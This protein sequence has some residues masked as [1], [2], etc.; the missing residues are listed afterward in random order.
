MALRQALGASSGELMR[1][2]AIPCGRM[3]RIFATVAGVGGV[4][5]SWPLCSIHY[6]PRI[7]WPRVFRWQI[8]GA[9]GS[10]AAMATFA[11]LWEPACEPQN[12]AAYDS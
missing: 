2:D 4:F 5:L 1:E 3:T 7:T 12:I 10:A 11:R 8:C 9:V 6:G